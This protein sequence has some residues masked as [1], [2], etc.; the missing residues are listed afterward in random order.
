MMGDDQI[1]ARTDSL[2]QHRLCGIHSAQHSGYRFCLTANLPAYVV[3]FLR[4]TGRSKILECGDDVPL[5]DQPRELMTALNLGPPWV[6]FQVLR[7][8]QWAPALHG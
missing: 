2:V 6:C 1:R 3:P 5:A 7:R 4:Q 8:T